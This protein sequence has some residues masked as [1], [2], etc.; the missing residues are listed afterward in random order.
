VDVYEIRIVLVYRHRLKLTALL[1]YQGK[2]V[3]HAW[4][5]IS[6]IA[7]WLVGLG[8]PRPVQVDG[9]HFE[10]L[11][12]DSPLTVSTPSPLAGRVSEVDRIVLDVD[13][14]I[15]TLWISKIGYNSV[16]TDEA[17]KI[18]RIPAVVRP[19]PTSTQ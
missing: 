17:V 16:W 15:D 11:L 19:D 7:G 5:I 6:L 12:R 18:N 14:P 1:E 9:L 3:F 13:E 4:D 8:S 10:V 2:R